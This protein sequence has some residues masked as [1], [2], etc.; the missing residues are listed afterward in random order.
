[1]D[2]HNVATHIIDI[3][4]LL[5]LAWL[6]SSS[7]A[8]QSRRKTPLLIGILLTVVIIV[9]EVGTIVAAQAGAEFRFLN[10]A[11][12]LIGFSLTPLVPLAVSFMFDSGVLR[13]T[14]CSSFP[15]S[16]TEWRR[17]FLL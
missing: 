16:S 1:M 7:T 2:V 13:G 10:Q 8:V 4:A 11:C 15:R 6:L 14:I 3:A 12:N 17:G 9:A 5:C